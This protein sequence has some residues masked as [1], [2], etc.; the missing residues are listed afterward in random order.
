MEY[1]PDSKVLLS[2]RD[3]K[4]WERSFR[5]TIWTMSH[6]RTL[7]PLLAHARAE[8]DPRW[9]AY[10]EFVD[11]MFWGPQGTFAKGYDEPEQL[12]EQ[13][14][15]HTEA[16]K[17]VVPADRLLVWRSVTAGSRCAISSKSRS[18]TSRCRTS[19]TAT[20]SWNA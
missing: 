15:A 8:I 13:M 4:S 11:R 16:V 7:M 20:R 2:V 9:H 18:P 10:L 14:L 19:T 5:Q 17:R 3:P 6:G 12:I 1:Y